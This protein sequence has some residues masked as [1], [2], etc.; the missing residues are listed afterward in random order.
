MSAIAEKPRKKRVSAFSHRK[1]DPAYYWMTVPAMILFMVFL[2]WPFLR[3][4]MYS[5]TNSKGYGKYKWIGLT[6]YKAMFQDERIGRAYLFTFFIAIVVTILVNLLSMFIAVLLN[7]KIAFRNGFRAIYFIPYTLAVLVVGYVFKYIF[8]MPIPELGKALGIGWLSES[9]ITSESLAWAPI[10]V[11]SVWQGVAYT[12]LI[13]LAGLQTIDT[14]IYEAAALDGVNAWQKFWQITFPLIGPFFTINLVLT[15]KGALGTFDQ[16]VALTGG[17]P[18]SATETV[19]YLIYQG[20]LTGGEY[21]YQTANAVMFFIVL[22]IIA[23]IQLKFF[24]SK[25]KV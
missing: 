25:E 19:T 14:D 4:V 18:N 13:Y 5:F 17:G 23:F 11:L 16:V 9:M 2:Y 8:M 22:A 24:G 21:A 7:S 6:N 15:M 3:G 1:V 10:V 20:G 12:T